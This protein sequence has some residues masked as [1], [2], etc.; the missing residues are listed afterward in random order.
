MRK[1][2]KES[3]IVWDTVD[4]LIPGAQLTVWSRDNGIPFPNLNEEPNP[5]D[6]AP[7]GNITKQFWKN[8]NIGNNQWHEESRYH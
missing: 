7:E 4:L 3:D 8:N 1:P 6:L 2:V 5:V